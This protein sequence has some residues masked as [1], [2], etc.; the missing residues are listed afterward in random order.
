MLVCDMCGKYNEPSHLNISLEY[1]ANVLNGGHIHICPD[2]KEKY[3]GKEIMDKL[4]KID[5]SIIDDYLIKSKEPKFQ[6]EQ[7]FN[8]IAPSE[9]VKIIK[10][11]RCKT[12]S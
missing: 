7:Y 1:Q 6:R 10:E 8:N 5:L 4:K 3:Y 11:N 9:M 2:C 12:K